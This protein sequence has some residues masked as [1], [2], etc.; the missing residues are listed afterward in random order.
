MQD[1]FHRIYEWY[2][3]W[4]GNL[5]DGKL[6]AMIRLTLL[7]AAP[8]AVYYWTFISGNREGFGRFAVAVL[9]EGLVLAMPLRVPCDETARASILTICALL[10]V[11][12]PGVHPF[13]VYREA[14]RQRRLRIALYVV[15]GTLLL[16][17]MLWS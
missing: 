13:L 14:G 2:V 8:T 1:I 6:I 17:G 7:F 4:A 12:L 3:G 5:S 9:T 16:I 15:M 10:L 11:Y